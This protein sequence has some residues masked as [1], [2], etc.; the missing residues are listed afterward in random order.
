M[1]KLSGYGYESGGMVGPDGTVLESSAYLVG[2]WL[3]FDHC[4]VSCRQVRKFLEGVLM[5]ICL[6]FL[7]EVVLILV[8]PASGGEV[9]GPVTNI[10]L[11]DDRVASR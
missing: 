10:Y 8:S 4:R 11:L 6:L 5:D 7:T 9:I 2:G 3:T 1:G